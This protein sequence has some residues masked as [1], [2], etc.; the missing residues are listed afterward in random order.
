MHINE[1]RKAVLGPGESDPLGPYAEEMHSR[2]GST[3]REPINKT[4]FRQIERQ[5][6]KLTSLSSV[7][8]PLP[9]V[10]S[11]CLSDAELQGQFNA[12]I[13]YL[14]PNVHANSAMED[15]AITSN[16]R[17]ITFPEIPGLIY[18]PSMI[19][20]E[21]QLPLLVSIMRDGMRP[22]SSSNLD[23]LF[24]NGG[25]FGTPTQPNAL[26]AI[27]T[28]GLFSKI[29]SDTWE[30]SEAS[31]S[32]FRRYRWVALGVQYDWTTKEYS[33]E[34]PVS[35][36]PSILANLSTQI[37]ATLMGSPGVHYKPEAG[38]INYYQP[39]DTLTGHVDRS[40]LDDQSP[41]VSISIGLDC[42]FLVG[43]RTR[44][45][46]V[47][48]FRL[49]S[50]DVLLLA[51]EC[52]RNYHGVPLVISESLPQYLKTSTAEQHHVS[53]EEILA[54]R[55]ID[56]ARINVNIRQVWPSQHMDSGRRS[57]HD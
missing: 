7:D 37:C 19:Q 27:P 28:E 53:D 31:V 12:S 25:S 21:H 46:P 18:A 55:L 54:L 24:R 1:R 51:N 35:L 16:V 41:L 57:V 9:P 33:W 4:L 17:I 5:F 44:D 38:I 3:A 50:G 42:I 14:S 56:D 11:G 39:G 34:M 10:V 20:P 45:D 32:L 49:S 26:S 40:E 23:A 29:L 15:V 43:G 52:R 30:A 36:I 13:S 48:P 47:V 6:K 2:K 8:S 22:N